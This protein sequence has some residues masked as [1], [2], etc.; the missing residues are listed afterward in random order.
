MNAKKTVALV[1]VSLLIATRMLAQTE[2]IKEADRFVK[3]IE[4]TSQALTDTHLKTKNAL[5]S[6]NAL[7]KG[8]SMDMKGD[9]KKLVKA[10]KDMNGEVATARKTA[11]DMDKQAAVYFAARSTAISQIG[12]ASMRDQAKSRLD[13]SKQ[14]YEQVK[15]SMKG[16]GDA[17][18]P[19]ARDLSD[20]IKYLG[21]ELTPAAAASLKPQ[22]ELLNKQGGTLFTQTDAAVTTATTYLNTLKAG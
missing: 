16:A 21:G 10:E 19:F 20:H 4:S 3:A 5:D 18:A 14:A 1:I 8:D 13:E 22:G 17:F 7:I 2:G 12:D 6:Y 9:Y 11:G 15:K